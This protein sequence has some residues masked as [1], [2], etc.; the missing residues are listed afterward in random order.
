MEALDIRRSK[1]LDIVWVGIPHSKT[2][3]AKGKAS[4]ATSYGEKK[5][6][7]GGGRGRNPDPDSG[8]KKNK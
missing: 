8:K 6:G 2:P 4:L 1:K 3:P 5:G 7:K